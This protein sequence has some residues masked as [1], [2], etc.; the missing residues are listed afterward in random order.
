MP[1]SAPVTSALRP[2]SNRAGS[3]SRVKAVSVTAASSQGRTET[4]TLERPCVSA[5]AAAALADPQSARRGRVVGAGFVLPEH[6]HDAV[7]LENRRVDGPEVC[8]ALAP[9]AR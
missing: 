8:E 6:R 4:A 7:R 5:A 1:E 9:R 3:G 2:P